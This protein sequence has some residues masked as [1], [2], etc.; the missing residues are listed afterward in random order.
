[1]TS[2]AG[3]ASDILIPDFTIVRFL[4]D[5][6]AGRAFGFSHG[7]LE[8]TA[9]LHYHMFDIT[10]LKLLQEFVYKSFMSVI[11]HT[12]AKLKN[13]MCKEFTECVNHS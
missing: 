9:L 13:N 3:P 10:A 2:E 7:V 1:M 11:S 12:N 5:Q 4:T 6:R 8:R